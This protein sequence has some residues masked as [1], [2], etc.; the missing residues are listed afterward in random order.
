MRGDHNWH[1]R[2]KGSLEVMF[3]IWVAPNRG[4]RRWAEPSTDW[5]SGDSGGLDQP[6]LSHCPQ[7]HCPSS[8]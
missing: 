5:T 6:V 1:Q 4:E 2:P 8:S 7:L 3:G